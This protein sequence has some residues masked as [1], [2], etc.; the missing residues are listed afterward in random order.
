MAEFKNDG[1]VVDKEFSELSEEQK[2][3]QAKEFSEGNKDLEDILLF[4]WSKGIKTIAC[5]KGHENHG[6][7]YVFFHI[8]KIDDKVFR[9]I[10]VGLSDIQKCESEISAGRLPE[11][12][13]RESSFSISLENQNVQDFKKILKVL[14]EALNNELSPEVYKEKYSQLSE[15]RR[16]FIESAMEI[17]KMGDM[18]QLGEIDLKEY[19]KHFPDDTRLTYISL[20]NKDDKTS[21]W[22]DL[23]CKRNFKHAEYETEITMSDGRKIKMKSSKPVDSYCYEEVGGKFYSVDAKTGEIFSL[24]EEEFKARGYVS[25]KEFSAYIHQNVFPPTI[26]TFNKLL[27]AVKNSK[28][29]EEEFD[30]AY[31]VDV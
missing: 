2:A 4:L 20:A 7:P 3:E 17:K 29:A 26:D 8:N 24:P 9:R 23:S 11:I 5:C 13:F 10:L 12:G 14:K 28:T 19:Y 22:F 21:M 18:S 27:D 30:A 6:R 15:E 25:K 16:E 1:K 31:R